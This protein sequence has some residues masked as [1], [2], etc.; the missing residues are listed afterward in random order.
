MSPTIRLVAAIDF[1]T[2]GT[3][4]AWAFASER[5]RAPKARRILLHEDWAAQ[6]IVYVK[7][8]TA[9][10]LDGSGSV[11]EWGYQAQERYLVESRTR[12]DL[13]YF[14]RFKMGLLPSPDDPIDGP[15]GPGRSADELIVAYL[16]EFHRFA[17]K[18]I[19]DG[20]GVAEDEILWCLTV[21]AI[22][23]DRERQI[24]RDCAVA[25]GFPGGHDRLLIA[26][27]PEV[28]ALYCRYETGRDIDVNGSRFM[29]VDAGGGTVDITSYEVG[30]AGLSG[31]VSA[32]PVSDL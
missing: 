3:G 15:A 29:V 2:H 13:E 32:V 23:R 27:E 1:G 7:N 14:Q 9:L 21:P 18:S 8:L 16:R 5:D 22:W 4:F 12:P 24:M 6:P 26:V 31:A 19:I 10:L 17:M 30:A 11:L 28:A 20:S 25:A